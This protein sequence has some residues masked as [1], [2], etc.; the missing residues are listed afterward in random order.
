MP[1]SELAEEVLNSQPQPLTP[2]S[3]RVEPPQ[4]Q[5]QL[6]LRL[7]GL[8]FLLPLLTPLEKTVFETELQRIINMWLY[9]KK[10]V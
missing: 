9:R 5:V 8:P 6:E 10:L 2:E 1:R 7:Q 4:Q 3:E